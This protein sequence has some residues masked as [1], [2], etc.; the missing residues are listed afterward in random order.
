MS[1]ESSLAAA[2][3]TA[4]VGRGAAQRLRRV[5]CQLDLNHDREGFLS[6]Y[7]FTSQFIA[8]QQ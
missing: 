6:F 1:G 5:G 4:A 8:L 7:S 2:V 3:Q